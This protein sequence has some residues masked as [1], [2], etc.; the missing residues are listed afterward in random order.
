MRPKPTDSRRGA[1]RSSSYPPGAPSI[2]GQ[3]YLA[4]WGSEKVVVG[5]TKA[6]GWTADQALG[7][8]SPA[9]AR[10]RGRG[11]ALGGPGRGTALG[12]PGGPGP[13]SSPS[14]DDSDS[15]VE[16]LRASMERVWSPLKGWEV[17]EI[18]CGV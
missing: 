7:M 15:D 10:R 11:T 14:T 18:R 16:L 9:E 2:L 4:A 13:A 8:C 5:A 17:S 12:G 1:S 6:F 3:P